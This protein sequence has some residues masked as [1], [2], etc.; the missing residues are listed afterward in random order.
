MHI[1]IFEHILSYILFVYRAK[2]GD[3]G[4][5][6]YAGDIDEEE[7]GQNYDPSDENQP[8][9]QH[10]V[11]DDEEEVDDNGQPK[12]SRSYITSI[13]EQLQDTLLQTNDSGTGAGHAN[14]SV[15]SSQN[16]LFS[17]GMH[18]YVYILYTILIIHLTYVL[19]YIGDLIQVSSGELSNLVARIISIN[20]INKTV[21]V[22]PYNSI[23]KGEFSIEMSIILKY[24]PVGSHVKV[25]LG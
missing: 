4:F 15:E 6:D 25:S 5:D 10:A 18:V 7:E 17:T 12:P 3:A 9:Q 16:S 13:A 22:I 8:P 11:D 24:I 19:H 21:S 1:L 23:L 20:N 2:E 14:K